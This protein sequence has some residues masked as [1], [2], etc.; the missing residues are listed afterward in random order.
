MGN[1]KDRIDDL[2]GA[3]EEDAVGEPEAEA[4]AERRWP[5]FGRLW[6]RFGNGRQFGG[7]AGSLRERGFRPH[8]GSHDRQVAGSGMAPE[9]WASVAQAGYGP[10]RLAWR[11][12][13]RFGILVV[14]AVIGLI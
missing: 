1:D 11:R 2:G 6:E 9:V 3:G 5:W 10:Q 8:S 7:H 14:Q 12:K 13:L 4:D